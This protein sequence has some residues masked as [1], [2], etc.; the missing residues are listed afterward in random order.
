MRSFLVDTNLPPDVAVLLVSL[1]YA[2]QHTSQIGLERA[3]DRDIWRHAKTTGCS[4]VT[5]D[6][7]FVLFKAA[8]P[9]GP[10]VVWVRIGNALRRVILH[11][12]AN[13][14]PA[15]VAKLDGG[16]TVVELK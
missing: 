3:K 9:T 15:V 12:L 10:S 11:K 5:K 6:E 16:E 1:G 13:A 7:D 14:W 8:D 2:A 4:I